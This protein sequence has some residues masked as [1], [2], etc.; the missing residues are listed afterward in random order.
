MGVGERKRI[1]A[2]ITEYRPNSHADVIVSKFL[3]GYPTDE[4]MRMPRVDVVSMYVDQFAD[5]DLSRQM[6][7]KHGVPI[8]PSIRQALVRSDKA[9]AK[10]AVDG[11]LLIGEH[12]DFPFNEREQRLYPR[13][14]FFEQIAAVIATSGRAATTVPVFNDKGLA[15]NWADAKWMYDRACELG[16]PFMA[17]SSVPVGWRRPFVELEPDTAIDECVMIGWAGLEIYGFHTLEALQCMVE[18]RRGGE[19]GVAAVRFLGGQEVWDAGRRGVWSRELAEAALD[20]IEDKPD[21]PMEQHATDPAL[22]LIEYRD[23]LTVP[24]LVLS[25]Y[26]RDF[27][28]AVRTG[29][30]TLACEFFLPRERPHAHF[31]YLSLNVEEMFVTGV[32]SYPVERTLLTT[33]TLAAV[34]DSRHQGHER[35]ETPWLDVGYR[36]DTPIPYLPT[37]PR[38]TG[39]CLD[40]GPTPDGG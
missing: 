26:V 13:K 23:G 2:I 35:V 20:A 30:R 1:A 32:A 27:A 38:P 8:Y 25:G 14:C 15:Y 40:P 19:T 6:S 28:I 31:S 3:E 34:L 36:R 18:R 24:V 9:D 37:G 29:T 4:G 7:S 5:N 39:A 16:I 33:G 21:G 12:G 11:V 10:L 17:G 22:F